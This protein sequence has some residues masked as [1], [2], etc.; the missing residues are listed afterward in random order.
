MWPVSYQGKQAISSSLNFLLLFKYKLLS[1]GALKDASGKGFNGC[2]I[3]H[4]KFAN[5]VTGDMLYCVKCELFSA[6]GNILLFAL[7][8]ME[9]EAPKLQG[10]LLVHDYCI[11]GNGYSL[12]TCDY[13][14]RQ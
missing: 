5:A 10:L 2:F 3:H 11:Y 13:S 7:M 12:P 9:G 14:F 4:R 1:F 6:K 8:H